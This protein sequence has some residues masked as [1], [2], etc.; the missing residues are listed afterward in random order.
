MGCGKTTLGEALGRIAGDASSFLPADCRYLDLD[1]LI[2]QRERMSVRRIFQEKGESGFR[3]LE[4]EI[5]RQ[6]ASVENVIVGCGGGTP[7]HGDN[8]DWM[9]AHGLT[10]L[11]EA[12]EDVLVRRLLEAQ[13][14]RPLLAGLTPDELASFVSEKLLDRA[15][16][17]GMAQQRFSSD[18]LESPKEIADTVT[19]FGRMLMR[20]GHI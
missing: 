14:Q 2:E 11:L 19:E 7:C 8:M 12:S 13:E 17:Y 6:A 16:W 5:L 10:V 4:A 20:V 1:R 3:S 9:N 15:H 18:R